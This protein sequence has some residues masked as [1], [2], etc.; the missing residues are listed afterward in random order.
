M[1]TKVKGDRI[2]RRNK[3]CLIKT[4]KNA[5]DNFLN[6]IVLI[7]KIRNLVE[8]NILVTKKLLRIMKNGDYYDSVEMYVLYKCIS[9]ISWN[10]LFR[11]VSFLYIDTVNLKLFLTCQLLF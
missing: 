2:H 1:N 11:C 8:I 3:K 10:I 9:L 6:Q 7:I 5:H 4:Y